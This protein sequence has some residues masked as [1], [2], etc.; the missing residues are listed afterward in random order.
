M[1]KSEIKIYKKKL[2]ILTTDSYLKMYYWFAWANT[3]HRFALVFLVFYDNCERFNK[4]IH[5]KFSY[6]DTKW[7]RKKR[8]IILI[9]FR[10]QK[11]F[12]MFNRKILRIKMSK[13]KTFNL[14]NKSNYSIAVTDKIQVSKSN[15]EQSTDNFSIKNDNLFDPDSCICGALNNK[16]NHI[17]WTISRNGKKINETCRKRTNFHD[18]IIDCL[19]V[20]PSFAYFSL[21][22][23]SAFIFEW[24]VFSLTLLTIFSQC[25]PSSAQIAIIQ[26]EFP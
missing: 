11:V 20:S 18:F 21:F 10:F 17:E 12:P 15:N 22:A 14:T 24:S 23:Y 5:R 3:S 4:I 8:Q 9:L 6:I 1:K 13:R 2:I 7:C 19:A 26:I 16:D 25:F